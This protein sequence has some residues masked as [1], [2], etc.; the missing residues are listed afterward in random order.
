VG[1]TTETP[2]VCTLTATSS[3][4]TLTGTVDAS[5]TP[6]A[7]NCGVIHI[8][9]AAGEW[10]LVLRYESTTASGESEPTNVNRP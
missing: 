1:E 6:T 7:V 8:P 5:T 10:S 4:Q 9:A 3:T 2:G